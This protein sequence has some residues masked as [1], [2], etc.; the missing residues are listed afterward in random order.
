MK[1]EKV[2]CAFGRKTVNLIDLNAL[3]Y[4][5]HYATPLTCRGMPIG[6]A[7][8]TIRRIISDLDQKDSYLVGVLDSP[9]NFRKTVAPN[10][11]AGRTKTEGISH[12]RD[13]VKQFM[14]ALRIPVY[15]E[16][17]FE[18]DD[19]IASF[20]TLLGRDFNIFVT[21]PD[22]DLFKLLRYSSIEHGSVFAR[23]KVGDEIKLVTPDDIINKYGIQP[24]RFSEY[25]MLTGDSCD[26]IRGIKGV[27]AKTASKML[28]MF[29]V[30][31]MIN[32]YDSIIKSYEDGVCTL[33]LF[34]T[35]LKVQERT[36]DEKNRKK[37]NKF[38]ASV[39]ENMSDLKQAR[40]LVEL[41]DSVGMY[42]EANHIREDI[43]DYHGLNMEPDVE[44]FEELCEHYAFKSFQKYVKKWSQQGGKNV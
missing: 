42:P 25:L 12:Q 4:A 31:E 24:E 44:A 43:E 33:P 11:K 30:Y 17:N 1:Y 37:I 26:S 5:G 39:H 19:L 3:I 20:N 29:S 38:V 15:A 7:F 14:K 6:G 21:S 18:A 22:K 23:K 41:V 27:G 16:D 9:N 40:Y 2:D 36:T 28:S 32:T 34:A 10:Y 35:A 13:V 8:S